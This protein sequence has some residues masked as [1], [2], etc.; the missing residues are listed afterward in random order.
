MCV[1][2]STSLPAA[3]AAPPEMKRSIFF[4]LLKTKDKTEAATAQTEANMAMTI[5]AATA[6]IQSTKFLNH[7][8]DTSYIIRSSQNIKFVHDKVVVI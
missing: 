2:H 8:E 3:I 1:G 4:C 6:F 7:I 5:M